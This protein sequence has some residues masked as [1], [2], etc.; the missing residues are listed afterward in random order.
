MASQYKQPVLTLTDLLRDHV[1]DA[2]FNHVHIQGLSLDSRKVSAQYLFIALNGDTVNGIEFINQAIEKG[3]AAV[4]WEAETTAD[5]ININWR[6]NAAGTAVPIIAIKNLRQ[7][8]GEFADRFYAKPSKDISVCGIT[9]TNGKTSCADFIAQ[10]MSVDGPCGLMGTLGQGIY[11]ALTETGYT[12]PDAIVCHQWLARIKAERAIFAVMEVSSHA[13]V[14]GRVSGIRFD[15]AVFTNLSHEHLDFHSDM[16]SYSDAKMQLFRTA[17]LKNAIINIDDEV[18]RKIAAALDEKIR[19]IRYGF[20]ASHNPDVYASNV[21]LDENGLSMDVVTPW[22]KARLSAPVIGDFNASNL[23]AVLTVMLVQGIA[24]EEA[25]KRINTIKSVAGRM[26]RFGGNTDPLVVVDF[27]HTPDALEHV[28]VSLR[29]HTRDNLWCVF[30]CGGDRD[31]AKRALMGA[32]AEQYADH[33]VLTD[34]NPRSENAENIIADIKSGIKSK[35]IV[36]EQNRHL[37]IHYAISQAKAGDVVL[38]AGKGHENYQLIGATKYPF[39][40]A[41]EVLQQLARRAG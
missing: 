19:C 4:L 27:A 12:T 39:N 33:I 17:G 41:E 2:Q 36:V 7:L 15:S 18:G 25:V 9:G 8:V 31:K 13:L 20:N 38:I 26:Q 35:N 6:K 21:L 10:V 37:A 30:G 34:D 1:T 3:A 5:P 16:N 11:P 32:I 28:L 24:L 14:Q 40:D 22:G 23:L 29:Q